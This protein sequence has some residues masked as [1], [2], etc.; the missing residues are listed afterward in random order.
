MKQKIN[1]IFI[2]TS[3]FGLNCFQELIKNNDFNILGVITQ[4]DKKVGRKQKLTF[5]PIKIE[6]QKNNLKIWQPEKINTLLNELS[7]LKIDLIITIAYGQ[8]I[9]LDILN[10]PKFSCLNVH[11]SLL[12]KYRGASCI[13]AAILNNDQETG[14]TI[15]KMDKGLDTG[16]IL[17]QEKIKLNKTDTS[18][19]LYF[20]LQ[21]LSSNILIPTIQD[22]LQN[23]IISQ[24]QNNNKA[25]YVGLLKKQ[26]G[27]INWQK[28]A[29]E[30][31]CFIRARQPWPEAFCEFKGKKLKIIKVESEILEINDYEIEQ[32]FQDN[33]KIAVQCGKDALVFHTVQLEGKKLILI[34]DFINGYVD[35]IKIKLK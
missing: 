10:L 19:D 22:Y 23:K 30:I 13:Q 6:A 7:L 24:K 32:V 27:K 2:G 16:P 18:G 25:S 5:S 21:K 9:P 12:P 31:E 20:K 1:T 14:V 28:S 4:P 34:K 26:D 3:D 11:G 33:N 35:F 8:I 17:K 15:M 29:Q